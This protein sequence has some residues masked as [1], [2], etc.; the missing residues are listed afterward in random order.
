MILVKYSEIFHLNMILMENNKINLINWIIFLIKYFIN[1]FKLFS[2][3]QRQKNLSRF[4][5]NSLNLKKKKKHNI[6]LTCNF[7]SSWYTFHFSPRRPC[8]TLT[9]KWPFAKIF[10]NQITWYC[11][12]HFLN[13]YASA[14]INVRFFIRWW[15]MWT[16]TAS[17]V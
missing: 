4:I 1:K 14:R 15:R 6:K 7:N 3:T 2:S 12:C 13:V 17:K 11:C 9:L 8:M 5:L 16:S 10:I